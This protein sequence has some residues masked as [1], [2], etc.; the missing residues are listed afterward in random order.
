MTLDGEA[1]KAW[2]FP[3]SE[4]ISGVSEGCDG[5][6]MCSV[7]SQ[8]ADIRSAKADVSCAAFGLDYSAPTYNAPGYI[9]LSSQVQHA[10]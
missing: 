4:M 10:S 8:D 5:L 6:T 9:P 1:A 2:G 7:L 3:G